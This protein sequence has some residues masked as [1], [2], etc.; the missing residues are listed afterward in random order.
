MKSNKTASVVLSLAIAFL[1]ALSAASSFAQ[2]KDWDPKV[3]KELFNDDKDGKGKP[4]HRLKTDCK[5]CK[6]EIADLQAAL[7]NWYALQ[8]AE[9]E[10]LK[11]TG[12]ANPN[13][14][15]GD[16]QKKA[17]QALVDEAMAG[18][19]Q[20]GDKGAA[21]KGK[22]EKDAKD[23]PKTQGDK[24][25]LAKEIERL[26]KALKECVDKKCPPAVEK[27][28][29]DKEPDKPIVEDPNKP[30]TGGGGTSPVKPP[31]PPPPPAFDI[32]IPSLPNCFDTERDRDAYRKK[33]AELQEKIT[34]LRKANDVLL[35]E[36]PDQAWKQYKEQ[37]QKASEAIQAQNFPGDDGKDAIDNVKVPCPKGGGGAPPPKKKGKTATGPHGM[38]PKEIREEFCALINDDK[39]DVEFT[40]TGETAGYV[41]DCKISNLTD[42][43]LSCVIPPMVL[44]SKSGKNQDYACPEPK[45]VDVGPKESK[46][47]PIK[48]VCLVRN[49]TPVGKDVTGDLQINDCQ[50]GSRIPNDHA[51]KFLN[52]ATSIFQAADEL[53]KDGSLKDIPYK[54]PEK[55][56]DIVVQWTTWAD[57]RISEL[58]GVPPATKEDLRKVVY[59]QIEEKGPMTPETKKKVDQGIDTIFEKIE[60]TSEKAKDL[61]KAPGPVD[62]TVPAGPENVSDNVPPGTPPQTGDKPRERRSGLTWPKPVQDWWDKK[63]AADGAESSKKFNRKLYGWALDRFF[64]KSKY[65][66]ELKTGIEKRQKTLET[67]GV[68][69]VNDKLIKERDEMKSALE[70]LEK[71]LEK[72][73]Q[74][75]PEGKKA[76]AEVAE[77]EKAADKAGAAE[78][79]AGKNLD[80]AVKEE[81]EKAEAAVPAKW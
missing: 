12:I 57:P 8:L 54:D 28:K 9:G 46:T 26:A 70:K 58:T 29:D 78:K 17:G 37:L 41:A 1:F 18:L 48:G 68:K 13:F 30:S 23:N 6:K 76:F 16:Q 51:D 60:L 69:E 14:K 53:L 49:K 36:P 15:Q 20:P 71:Q 5:D 81:V 77:A 75:T 43:P 52:I 32:Q 34:K 24:G 11:K 10:E 50:D 44:E 47:V 55:K 4:T 79:E 61:E 73:F 74:Q 64:A 35:A 66:N 59:K 21:A 31:K 2:S 19:N 3:P 27:K 33:L 22:Q 42:E 39:I 63:K 62:G 25:A 56:K 80:P 65:W 40:G 45:T 72:D 38:V 67:S 7:D